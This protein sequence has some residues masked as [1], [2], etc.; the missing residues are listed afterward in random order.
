MIFKLYPTTMAKTPPMHQTTSAYLLAKQETSAP[1]RPTTCL[2][3][4]IPG[5]AVGRAARFGAVL[6][7]QG[8][9]D[10]LPFRISNASGRATELW[11]Q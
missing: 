10:G 11:K 8:H 7:P 3:L 1:L 5:A 6:C 2:R 4:S 9:P